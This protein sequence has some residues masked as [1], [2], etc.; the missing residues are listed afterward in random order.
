MAIE[1]DS[2][3]PQS[4]INVTPLVDVVL[5][6]LIIFMVV[7][8]VL[9]MGLDVEI[10]PKVEVTAPPI[11][12]ELT[13]IVI[14]VRGDG[15]YINKERHETLDALRDNLA[16]IMLSR[17]PDDRVVFVSAEDQVRFDRAVSAIDAARA[18]GA[19]K[20]GFLTDPPKSSNE[21]SSNEGRAT[22]NE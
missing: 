4:D 20:I 6:L 12:G 10:P 1:L 21:Q 22:S 9:Q 15:F 17:Q 3:A 5:V 18:A 2:G 16:P 7:T 19:Y 14:S 13:Q 8:P 11:P